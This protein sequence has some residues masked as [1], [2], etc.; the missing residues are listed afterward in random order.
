MNGDS[1][2]SRSKTNSHLKPDD[3]RIDCF[4]DY[5]G[6]CTVIRLLFWEI[7]FRAAHFVR[8]DRL[9]VAVCYHV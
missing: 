2:G 7:Y 4:M 8:W 1:T 5:Y 9:L 3:P 6:P